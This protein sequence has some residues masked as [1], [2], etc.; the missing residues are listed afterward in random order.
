MKPTATEIRER[1]E[2]VRKKYEKR[3]A[4]LAKKAIAEY[5]DPIIKLVKKIKESR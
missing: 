1:N 2:Q 5:F 3:F 4:D